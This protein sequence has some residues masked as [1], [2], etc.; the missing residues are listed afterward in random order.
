MYSV[1]HRSDAREQTACVAKA[2]SAA[3][4][5]VTAPAA[6][7]PKLL[8]SGCVAKSS[9]G[10]KACADSALEKGAPDEIILRSRTDSASLG[11]IAKKQ[12]PARETV[13]TDRGFVR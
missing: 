10:A 12:K 1:S 8:R 4:K 7:G 9:A 6:G 13:R 5:C 3:A 2:G 11:M